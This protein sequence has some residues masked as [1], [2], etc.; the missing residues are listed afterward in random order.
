MKDAPRKAETDEEKPAAGALTRAA[1]RVINAL[2]GWLDKLRTRLQPAA[3]EERG[4]SREPAGRQDKKVVEEPEAE[5]PRRGFLLRGLLIG[6]VALLVGA[7]AGGLLAYREMRHKLDAHEAV[8]DGLQDELEV[9]K[10]EAA[11][12]VNQMARFQRENNEFRQK[13][14]EARTEV[15]AQAARIDE[16]EKQ[17]ATKRPERP[18]AATRGAPSAVARPP[19]PPK[20]G[21]CAVG[22]AKAGEALTDCIEKFN[23]Q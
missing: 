10:K 4:R 14:L 5:Q 3:G 19:A 12:A 7:A 16:L 15:R 23:R 9:A 11:R 22:T 2:A 18:L 6:L 13:D 17:L 21:D 1:L 8:V 20:T